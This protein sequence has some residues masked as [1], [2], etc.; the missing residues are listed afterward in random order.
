MAKLAAD[1]TT[2]KQIQKVA[3][4]ENRLD[5]SPENIQDQHV[6]QKVPRAGIEQRRRHELPRVGIV[7][8]A[9]A[10]RQ[11][12]AHEAGLKR[13]E[14]ELSNETGNVQSDQRE[15]NNAPAFSPRP[16]KQ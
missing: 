2:Q 7:N 5:V 9:I 6:S 4:A 1:R 3:L 13:I 11:I 8:A 15:Q 10:Q 14:K 12:I 16:R